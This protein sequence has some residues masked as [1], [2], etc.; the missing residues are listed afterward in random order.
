MEDPLAKTIVRDSGE[1]PF[2]THLSPLPVEI[3][4]RQVTLRDRLTIATLVPFS[5]PFQ[6]PQGLLAYA[7]TL[8]NRE[9]E[10]GDTYPMTDQMTVEAF[11]NYWFGKL[12][13]V[14]PDFEP[15]QSARIRD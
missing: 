15:F 5:A 9:I 13:G 6:I 11:S 8:L 2:L 3:V 10:A 1:A 7:C 12:L 4:P 14:E